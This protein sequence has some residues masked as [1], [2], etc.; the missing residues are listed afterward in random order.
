M[1]IT[2]KYFY[3]FIFLFQFLSTYI[4]TSSLTDNIIFIVFHH[5]THTK[6]I[7]KSQEPKDWLFNKEK[8]EE[9]PST[10][11]PFVSRVY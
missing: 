6:F 10:K 8:K 3:F 1:N 4:H 2:Y 7:V 5:I 11:K 9:E